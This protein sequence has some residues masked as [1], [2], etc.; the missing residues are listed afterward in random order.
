MIKL[1]L[2]QLFIAS[3]YVLL[4]A[5]GSGVDTRHATLPYP[6]DI[7]HI[8]D[9]VPRNEPKSKYGNPAHYE[10]FG[11]RYYTLK[12]SQGYHQQ[13]IASWYGKKFHG[14][15][16]SSGETYDMYAM[17]AA[18]KTLPLPTYVEV[19]N[20]ENGKKVVVKV[21]DR[22]PFH[23]DRIIDLSYT[24]AKK[25]GLARNGTG[26]VDIRAITTRQSTALSAP[27]SEPTGVLANNT[28]GS[29]PIS[30]PTELYIQVGAFSTAVLAE[31]VKA[32]LQQKI[33]SPTLILSPNK[34]ESKLYRVRIGP[35]VNTEGS[36]KLLQALTDSGFHDAYLVVE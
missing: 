13:G 4:I 21:N 9:A 30:E 32:Q 16:T 27:I 35:L 28:A 29:A 24:A 36:D 11:K 19:T 14:K 34:L 7:A 22:G 33:A 3:L 8:P 23:G 20:I 5:C 6:P 25:L 17:T 1:A 18:H 31:Q 2:R 15:R 12:T 26:K 10:V